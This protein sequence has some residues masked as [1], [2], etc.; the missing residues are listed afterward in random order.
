VF[1]KFSEQAR[2]IVVAAQVQARLLA[3]DYVGA[4]HFLLAVLRDCER[5]GSSPLAQA[6]ARLGIEPAAAIRRLPLTPGPSGQP[7]MARLPFTREA[8]DVLAQSLSESK[9]AQQIAPEHLLL[10]VL[11]VGSLHPDTKLAESIV[12]A[13]LSYPDLS[14]ALRSPVDPG[15]RTDPD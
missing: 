13:N 2:R 11:T 12:A 9:T 10:A 3:H 7:E 6:L 14:R 4:E 1:D 5:D 15:D 8:K